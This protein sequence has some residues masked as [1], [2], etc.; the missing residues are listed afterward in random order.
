MANPSQITNYA[1]LP[2]P[3]RSYGAF[4]GYLLRSGAY[5][6]EAFS[7]VGLSTPPTCP[8]PASEL[9]MG[10]KEIFE[11]RVRW[12]GDQERG[13]SGPSNLPCRTIHVLGVGFSRRFRQ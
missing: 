10:P 12:N 7:S 11:K 13:F 6:P 8:C 1:D 9:G 4:P 3:H 2:P 5:F